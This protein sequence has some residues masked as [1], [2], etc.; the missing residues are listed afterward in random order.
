MNCQNPILWEGFVTPILAGYCRTECVGS[1][2]QFWRVSD[3]LNCQN[4][5]LWEGFVTPIHAVIV[6]LN[7]SARTGNLAGIKAIE[8][9][10]PHFVGGVCNPDSDFRLFFF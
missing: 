8:L 10:E 9:S 3:P 2:G 4:P 1:H 6:A 5:I 7:V